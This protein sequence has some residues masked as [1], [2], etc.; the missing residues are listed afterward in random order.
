[1]TPPTRSHPWRH[2][3]R[4]AIVAGGLV[5]AVLLVP[6]LRALV[7][8]VV[9]GLVIVALLVVVVGIGCL[10]AG[11]RLV[12]RH[13]VADLAVGVLVAWHRRWAHRRSRA[14]RRAGAQAAPGDWPPA[15]PWQPDA[16]G[17]PGGRR[18]V[19]VE[20]DGVGPGR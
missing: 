8:S 12:E 17:A 5:A 3:R 15:P 2:R 10:V 16:G 13:P 18:L 7:A 4:R 1:M 9:A 19:L 11:V 20:R 6:A 14:R